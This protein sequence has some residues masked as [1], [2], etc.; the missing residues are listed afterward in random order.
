[1]LLRNV[2]VQFNAQLRERV[3]HLAHESLY[4]S[5]ILALGKWDTLRASASRNAI[6][7]SMKT[8]NYTEGTAHDGD[9]LQSRPSS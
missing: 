2:L 7:N 8:K 4:H 9:R 1:V 5:G 6:K 3:L